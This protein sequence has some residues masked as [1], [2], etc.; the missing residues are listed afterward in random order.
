MNSASSPGWYSAIWIGL[1]ALLIGLCLA[2]VS[3]VRLEDDNL[4][5]IYASQ[6]STPASQT[7]ADEI[8]HTVASLPGCDL[9][10]WRLT[11]RERYKSNYIAYTGT[12]N[13]I[14][15]FFASGALTTP[16]AMVA[17]LLATKALYLLLGLG[18]IVLAAARAGKG[19]LRVAIVLAL[20]LL[21]I[22]DMIAQ[23]VLTFWIVDIDRPLRTMLQLG[24]SSVF[25]HAAHSIFGVT[26]RNVAMAAFALAFLLKW[27]GRTVGAGLVV[28]AIGLL[29]QTYGGIALAFFSLATALSA[30]AA[31][32][33]RPLRIL[34]T[35]SAVMY[36]VREQY[37]GSSTGLLLQVVMVLV[38][39]GVAQLAFLI[40]RS[41]AYQDTRQRLLRRLADQDIA[42][43]A[44]FLMLLAIVT[45][46]VCLIGGRLEQDPVSRLYFWSDLTIRI[47]SLIRFPVLVA[48]LF[49]IA[50]RAGLANPQRLPILYRCVALACAALTLVALTQVD[51]RAWTRLQHEVAQLEAVPTSSALRPVAEEARIYYLLASVAAAEVDANTARERIHMERPIQCG[52]PRLRHE[53]VT[54]GD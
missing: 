25:A 1:A 33:R 11:F 43:D 42:L 21:A 54:S 50:R 31:F 29:H 6:S 18:A 27:Q 22:S 16:L 41:R 2:R 14:Q 52:S 10:R 35:L 53:T 17:A 7:L 38:V 37:W 28:L 19:E 39:V 13:L 5:L 15:S 26:P 36:L 12:Q 30:P 34:L 9:E 23:R 4:Y 24:Y 44:L 51:S 46:V 32:E 48:A 47:W 40:V 20:L 45:T 3:S 49:Y 8:I